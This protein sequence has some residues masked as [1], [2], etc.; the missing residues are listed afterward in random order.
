MR[1][2]LLSQQFGDAYF[3]TSPPFGENSKKTLDALEQTLK[4]DQ[5]LPDFIYL[6]VGGGENE[7]VLLPDY[8][9]LTVLLKQ[10]LPKDVKFYHELHD[11]ASQASNAAIS[12]AKAIQLLFPVSSFPNEERIR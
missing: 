2:R 8:Y 12:I 4:Q 1:L 11:G 3:I 7:L 10:H 6:S 5:G 9:R